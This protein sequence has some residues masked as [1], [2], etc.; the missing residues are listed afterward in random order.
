VEQFVDAVQKAIEQG[1]SYPQFADWPIAIENARVQEAMQVVWR[2]MGE[3]DPDKLSHALRDA[4]WT[5]NSQIY[6]PDEFWNGVL[7][8]RWAIVA[9]LLVAFGVAGYFVYRREQTRRA[10]MLTLSLYRAHRHDA[11]KFLGTNFYGMADDARRE[12]W[13]V[14]ILIDRVIGLSRHFTDKLVPHIE[15]VAANQ[16][17]EMCGGSSTMRLDKVADLAFDGSRYIYEAKELKAPPGIHYSN[18]G[19][20]AVTVTHLPFALVVVLEEWFLNCISHIAGNKI[21]EPVFILRLTHRELLVESSGSL[22]TSHMA[23][24]QQRPRVS[25]LSLHQQGL[26]LIRNI[27]YYAHGVRVR[28]DNSESSAGQ[29]RVTLHIPLR[30]GV[31]SI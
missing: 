7:E 24:L 11:A 31:K 26:T 9:M 2:R 28:A 22:G 21:K 1:V 13:S 8:A 19:L 17:R 3:G 18:H 6:W 15:K 20:E 16:H 29:P 30:R 12:D 25:D 4:E 10:L 14:S 5:I 23:V 27:M